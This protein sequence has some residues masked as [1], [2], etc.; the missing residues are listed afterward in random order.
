MSRLFLSIAV[1]TV[2]SCAITTE[3]LADTCMV[4]PTQS[5]LV[6]G[7]FG[8]FR[9]G[10]TLNAGSTNKKPHPHHALDFSTGNA[11]QPL[12]ATT[13]GVIIFKGPKG[14]LGNQIAIKRPSGDI[15]TYNHLSGF[16]PKM[17][18]GVAVTAGDVIGTSGNTNAGSVAATGMAKHLHFVYGTAQKNAARATTFQA[19]AAKGPFNPAQLPSSFIQTLDIG[20]VTDPAPYFCAT[21][22]IKPDGLAS[23]LGADTKAQHAILFDTTPTNG[24][25]GGGKY[26]EAQ[27]IAANSTISIANAA[28]KKPHEVLADSDTFGALPEPPIGAYKTMS[29]SEMML[30]EA[31]RRFNDASYATNVAQLTVRALM[32]DYA[33]A[34]GVSNYLAEATL[35]KKEKVEALLAIYTSQK[36]ERLRYKTQTALEGA[37]KNSVVAAIK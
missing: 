16:A 26:D 31:T 9:G 20:W 13:D 8:E 18:V 11:N 34:S 32:I 17:A 15:V 27:I 35:R 29:T 1:V 33:R 5:N 14:Q 4:P 2:I 36:A 30:T 24:I 3:V 19:N 22:P 12:T 10:G 21:S 25:A 23:V 6:T 7:R 37:Q 28:G